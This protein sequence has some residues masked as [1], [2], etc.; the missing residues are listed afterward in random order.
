MAQKILPGGHLLEMFMPYR[1]DEKRMIEVLE[2]AASFDFYKNVELPSFRS[3]ENRKYVR[4]F[5]EK[6]GINATTFVT[7]Y[8]KERK[9]ALCDTDEG[10][11]QAAIA[12][13]KVH[14][15]MAA[16]TGYTNFGVPSGDDP[17]EENRTWAKMAMAD[18]MR[19]LAEFVGKLG[20]NLTIEPLDRYA[21]KKQLIGPMPET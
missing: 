7:P 6:N 4:N 12:L 1:D 20:M 18:S 9:L 17:G 11:R 19:E 16:E 2:K 13:V 14:A 8:V 21:Y 3:A 10:G 15:E 5:L